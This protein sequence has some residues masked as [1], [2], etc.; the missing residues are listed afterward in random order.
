MVGWII[1]GVFL[2]LILLILFLPL[3]V[4]LGYEGGSFHL[5]A[6]LGSVLIQLFPKQRKDKEKPEKQNKKKRKKLE[7]EE[8]KEKKPKKKKPGVSLNRDELLDLLQQVYYGIKRFNHA[9]KV[10]RFVL[11]YVAGGGD[12]YDTAVFYGKLNAV[13]SSLAPVCSRRFQ[14]KDCSVWTDVDFTAD[15][16]FLELGLAMTITLWRL[17]GVINRL[18]F[19][20]LKILLRSK[21]RRKREEKERKKAEEAQHPAEITERINTEKIQEEERMAANG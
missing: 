21:R 20:A 6:K 8:E 18:G 9:W 4:D 16:F 17:L 11:H 1:L 15:S 5:S 3:G 14:V 2:A 19:G 7:D 10:D 12:P 13:L